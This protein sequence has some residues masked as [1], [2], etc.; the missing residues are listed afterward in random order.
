MELVKPDI[1]LIFWQ[2]LSF[3]IVVFILGKFAW[4][5]I[6][7]SLH[8]RESS[9]EDAL[10]AAENAKAEMA[11]LQAD[12]EKIV[13]EAQKQKDELLAEARQMKDQLIAEAKKQATEEADK[14][15]ASARIAIENE[16]AT[17]VNE[18]KSKLAE[19][20]VSVAEKILSQ[21]L[22]DSGKYNDYISKSLDEFKLN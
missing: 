18:I 3:G 20:S 15:I 2:F 11:K 1:G 7:Q 13:A 22:T 5:P 16:K 19:L 6:L 4:K 17:A 12:N 10:Q 21:E 14:L 9:I 8:D